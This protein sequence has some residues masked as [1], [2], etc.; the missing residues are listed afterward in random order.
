MTVT[1][2]VVVAS[3]V[4]LTA[5]IAYFRWQSR[6]EFIG[7]RE[8][9]GLDRLRGVSATNIPPALF[10]ELFCVI[11]KEIGVRPGQLRTSDRLVEIFKVD[12]WQ[13]GGAQDAL[14]ELIRRTT[15]NRPPRIDT[16]QDLLTWLA[17]E[18]TGGMP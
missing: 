12:S 13:L 7:S 16:I 4:A 9:L 15:G 8:D 17:N 1:Q 14:E 18:Q 6:A 2:I 11:A 5:L 3:I 10:E